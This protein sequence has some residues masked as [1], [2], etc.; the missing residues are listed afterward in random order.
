[1]KGKDAMIIGTGTDIVSIDRIGAVL[2]DH[3]ARFTERCFSAEERA[4]VESRAAGNPAVAAAGYAK[5]WAAKEA[6]AKA[7][8]LGIREQIHLR[9]IAVINDSAGKPSILLAGGAKERLTRLTP[10]GMTVDIHISLSD[11]PPFA[12]AFVTIS[13]R[14]DPSG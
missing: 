1:V 7:L 5:R 3:G 2:D 10:E 4:H 13:A 14:Q 8:G 11:E 6:C 12:L 9:D